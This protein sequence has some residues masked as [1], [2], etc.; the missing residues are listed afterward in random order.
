MLPVASGTT[1]LE[2]ALFNVP[3]SLLPGLY[4]M[5]I[6]WAVIRVRYISL[7]NLILNGEVVRSSF[8]YP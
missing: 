5:V 1:T 7:V 6:A 4:S 3:G 2:T 8:K